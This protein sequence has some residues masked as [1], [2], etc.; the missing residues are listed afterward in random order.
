MDDERVR[1][2]GFSECARQK[3]RRQIYLTTGTLSVSLCE[4]KRTAQSERLGL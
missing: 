1:D 3:L 4:P 2:F